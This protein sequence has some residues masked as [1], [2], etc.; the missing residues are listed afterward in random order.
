MARGSLVAARCDPSECGVLIIGLIGVG[1]LLVLASSCS[2]APRT[3]QL[4]GAYQEGRV[5]EPVARTDGPDEPP[6]DGEVGKEIS[7][8]GEKPA[9]DAD[10]TLADSQ[11]PPS[12]DS[13][14]VVAPPRSATSEHT[15]VNRAEEPRGSRSE[16]EED[17][18][19]SGE[20]PGG[21]Y[22]ALVAPSTNEVEP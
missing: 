12:P 11:S 10:A 3:D 13:K 5:E 18:E 21:G 15:D 4:N 1:T 7:P 6:P 17:R 20:A 2:T 19:S 16:P 22:S 14:A 8:P 9:K